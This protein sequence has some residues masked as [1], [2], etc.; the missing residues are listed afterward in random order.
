[1]FCS[2]T[3]QKPK[4]ISNRLSESWGETLVRLLN[5]NLKNRGQ[6]HKSHWF[7]VYAGLFCV[8]IPRF[9]HIFGDYRSVLLLHTQ[10]EA[11]GWIKHKVAWNLIKEKGD[12]RTHIMQHG[13]QADVVATTLWQLFGGTRH[14]GNGTRAVALTCLHT[15]TG[16]G[17]GGHRQWTILLFFST[18]LILSSEK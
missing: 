1:M 9:R 14:L 2:Q 6:P 11:G 13:R 3:Q 7:C 18:G 17:G 16:W 15:G 8:T 5:N 4:Q 12:T 10:W